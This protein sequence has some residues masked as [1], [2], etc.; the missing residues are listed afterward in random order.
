MTTDNSFL[1]CILYHWNLTS[2]LGLLLLTFEKKYEVI[3]IGVE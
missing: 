3:L 1:I 2:I